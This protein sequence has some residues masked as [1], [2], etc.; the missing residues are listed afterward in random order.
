[1]QQAELSLPEPLP[2]GLTEDERYLLERG[3]RFELRMARQTHFD[4]TTGCV[5]W[6]GGNVCSSGYSRLNFRRAGQHRKI[7]V[8]RLALLLHVRRSLEGLEV[9]HRCC[10]ARCVNPLHL[11]AVPGAVNLAARHSR[12]GV[13]DP[14]LAADPDRDVPWPAGARPAEEGEEPPF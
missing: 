4:P 12:G 5:E 6:I 13:P 1:M 8:H 7:R 2:D 3:R 11:A 10:N 9:D 14:D